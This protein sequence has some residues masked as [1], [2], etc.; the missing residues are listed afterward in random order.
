MELNYIKPVKINFYNLRK[1]RQQ[2]N[3][4]NVFDLIKL[5]KLKELKK[6]I[7]N[8]ELKRVLEET[9]LTLEILINK[10]KNNDI[11][12]IILS[13][14]ISKKA[15]RQGSKDEC[16]Q[17]EICNKLSQKY[18]INIKNLSASAFRPKKRGKLLMKKK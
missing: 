12:T 15:S 6:I 14:R 10:C 2:I 13:G 5:N 17:I 16:T 4:K 9:N 8:Q 3:N 18:N 7:N 1:N 11:L